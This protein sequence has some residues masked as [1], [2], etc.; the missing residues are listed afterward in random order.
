MLSQCSE[1]N[2]VGSL[3]ADTTSSRNNEWMAD[4]ELINY[5][6][7]S[8]FTNIQSPQMV[9]NRKHIQSDYQQFLLGQFPVCLGSCREQIIL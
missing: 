4:K 1:V 7:L 5:L 2:V 8:L 9:L 3:E 6:N